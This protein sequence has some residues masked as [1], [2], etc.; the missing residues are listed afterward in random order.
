[1]KR[2]V[3]ERERAHA[4]MPDDDNTNEDDDT[5]NDDNTEADMVTTLLKSF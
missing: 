4:Q 5:N 2:R 3:E 1:M